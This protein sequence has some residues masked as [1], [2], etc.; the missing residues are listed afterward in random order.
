MASIAPLRVLLLL[1]PLSCGATAPA[2]TSIPLAAFTGPLTLLSHADDPRELLVF[3]RPGSRP[4]VAALAEAL[5]RANATARERGLAPIQLTVL[6]WKRDRH[7]PVPLAGG[8]TPVARIEA[9]VRFDVWLQ[10]FAEIAAAGGE[11]L[12][13][14]PGHARGG[15]ERIVPLL[16]DRWGARWLRLPRDA[17][18]S[19]NGAGNIEAL[20]DG[21]LLLGSNAGPG[22]TRFLLAH[23]YRGHQLRIDTAFL[24]IGHVDELFSHV[25][26]GPGRCDY[27]LVRA[28]PGLALASA[29]NDPAP[30][31]WLAKR[32]ARKAFAR[33]QRA[34]DR[35]IAAS[36][37]AVRAG[38]ASCPPP[39]VIPLPVLF[40]C[41]GPPD[42]PRSCR[43]TRPNAVNMTVLRRD[44]LIPDPGY[45]PFRT[46]IVAALVAAGQSPHLLP[47]GFHHE[48][49]GGV[50]CATNV[51][52]D[53]ARAAA[54]D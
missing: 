46:A 38:A 34:L 50:H 7:D 13:F 48:R 9:D 29:R 1:L 49:Q 35:R 37:A 28:S 18:G 47:A 5:E 15:L 42:A 4:F 25:V 36:A 45:A 3:E 17:P 20:P 22:L 30:P 23:G 33:T 14:D 10:D 11:T 27:A 26:T 2:V 43:A 51:R 24:A 41:K 52:R 32:L 21:R 54:P 31:R 8:A 19:A 44:L 40:D 16:A 53:P 12:L 39:A 6:R